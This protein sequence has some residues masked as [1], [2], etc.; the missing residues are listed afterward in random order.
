MSWMNMERQWR[1]AHMSEEQSEDEYYEKLEA[2]EEFGSY[3]ECQAK[4]IGETWR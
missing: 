3:D 1:K 4:S 2:D